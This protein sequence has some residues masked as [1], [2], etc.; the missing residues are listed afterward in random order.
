M[1][2]KVIELLKWVVGI[3]LTILGALGSYIYFLHKER[4][5]ADSD[6]REERV[7]SMEKQTDALN[8]NSDILTGLKTLL[9][10]QNRK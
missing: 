7:K 3:F 4:R 1:D 10:H 5:K 2:E 6:N 9:E 8:K